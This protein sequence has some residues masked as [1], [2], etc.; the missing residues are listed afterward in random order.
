M[1]MSTSKIQ[2]CVTV[3]YHFLKFIEEHRDSFGQNWSRISDFDH[4][5]F[6]AIENFVIKQIFN[7]IMKYK[8]YDEEQR[9]D[10]LM[11]GKVSLV[12]VCQFF[13]KRRSMTVKQFEHTLGE[14]VSWHNK[15]KKDKQCFISA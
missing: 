8:S 7:I 5:I 6:E 9:K 12:L 15:I 13:L 11:S 2:E 10:A 1:N 3:Y 14:I 4:I